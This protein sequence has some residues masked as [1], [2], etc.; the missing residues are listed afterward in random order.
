M[1][2]CFPFS[3]LYPDQYI[4]FLYVLAYQIS[5]L[6]FR[7]VLALPK[8]AYFAQTHKS[9]VWFKKPVTHL[10]LYIEANV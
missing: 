2:Y 6:N 8:T 4:A 7:A 1:G 5:Y 3:S 9:I 10:L